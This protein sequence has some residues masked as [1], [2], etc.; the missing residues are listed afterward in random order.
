MQFTTCCTW[1]TLRVG[2]S[3]GGVFVVVQLPAVEGTP[4]P[5]AGRH[6]L[7][8]AFLEAPAAAAAHE[9]LKVLF[10]QKHTD[11]CKSY[12]NKRNQT[13]NF[14]NCKTPITNPTNIVFERNSAKIR[15]IHEFDYPEVHRLFHRSIDEP[16]LS[17]F[18]GY[19]QVLCQ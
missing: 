8:F 9:R 10:S 7:H 2:T 19:F 14:R 13:Q 3:R 18:T 11:Q 16:R 15:S 4:L 1:S 17:V 5:P 12:H 6:I